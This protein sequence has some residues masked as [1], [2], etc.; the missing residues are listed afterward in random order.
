MLSIMILSIVICCA[1]LGISI[2]GYYSY[3]TEEHNQEIL[4]K[5]KEEL[6]QKEEQERQDRLAKEE[7]ERQDRLDK[8]EQERQ[9][10]LDKEERD[11]SRQLQLEE[12]HIQ[13]RI[14]R[15]EYRDAY[16]ETHFTNT[17]SFDELMTNINFVISSVW[18]HEE[19]Y[20][21]KAN[22]IVVPKIEEETT[23]FGVMVLNHMSPELRKQAL[24]YYSF[25]GLLYYIHGVFNDLI[26]KYATDRNELQ[27]IYKYIYSNNREQLKKDIAELRENSKA[28]RSN[29]NGKGKA[30]YKN[31]E[32]LFNS[33]ENNAPY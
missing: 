1:V 17:I 27:G 6:R 22:D 2:K 18:S 9:Y 5:E 25:D 3:L 29:N 13:D 15:E 4:K 23:K 26:W 11:W 16:N 24:L 10:R 8:E 28:E 33:F 31:F 20:Y 30:K 19:H 21:L 32:E 12:I 7:Q 14:K